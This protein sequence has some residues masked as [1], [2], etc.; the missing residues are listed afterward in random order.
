LLQQS[1]TAVMLLLMATSAFKLER[2][3]PSVM[4]SAFY[5]M[6]FHSTTTTT[7]EPFYGPF[8]GTTRV[9]RYQKKASFGL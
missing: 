8:S 3:F 6:C 7:P 5:A 1:F 9:S 2:K 4:L